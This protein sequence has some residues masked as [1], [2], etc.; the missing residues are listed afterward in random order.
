MKGDLADFIDGQEFRNIDTYQA[1]LKE[2]ITKVKKPFKI[3]FDP[4]TYIGIEVE[5]ENI[6][7]RGGFV[8]LENRQYLWQNVE[9]NSL[10]NN[11]RE[12]VSIP[13]KGQQIPYAVDTL[14]KAFT[15]D[16][17]CLGYEFTDRTSIHVHVNYRDSSVET[18]ANTILLYLLVEPLFYAFV[19]GDRDKNIF[20]VPLK[21]S[22][23][24]VNLHR[25]FKDFEN[26]RGDNYSIL[27]RWSKYNG[28]NLAPLFRYGT[29]EYRHLVGT[30]NQEKIM[31]WITSILKLKEFASKTK[32]E[33]L[34]QSLIELN[35]TSSYVA[36]LNDMFGDSFPHDQMYNVHELLEESTMFIKEIFAFDEK[37]YS[38]MFVGA[39]T[40]LDNPFY[41]RYIATKE[42]ITSLSKQGPNKAV[43]SRGVL[44]D[45]IN[46]NDGPTERELNRL[47]ASLRV[48]TSTPTPVT[49][50]FQRDNPPIRVTDEVDF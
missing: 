20:C 35:T 5:V 10:R 50:D 44:D 8:P 30:D 4:D 37:D 49:M 25:L 43:F 18:L 11:G 7:K 2:L 23:N 47:R 17:T 32:Y 28:L 31:T 41:V 34:K 29:I 19:G 3:E 6:F 36:L 12:F 45:P 39:D 13:I 48:S 40:S 22:D 14:F 46:W 21:E 24:L 42:F 16:K 26:N 33:D 38:I 9:D 27:R 15:K 1:P